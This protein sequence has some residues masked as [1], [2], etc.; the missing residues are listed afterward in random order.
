M[1]DLKKTYPFPTLTDV[2]VAFPVLRID[3]KLLAEA[4]ERGF[5][6]GDTPYNEL[7][8]S[9]FFFQ[10]ASYPSRRICQKEFQERATRYLKTLM[11]SSDLKHEEKEAVC[12]MLLSE[13]AE[14]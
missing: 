3:P 7:F 2:D 13:L 8:S 9:L 4:K 14:I 5:Y 11:G 10:A 6:N 1:T 12:A